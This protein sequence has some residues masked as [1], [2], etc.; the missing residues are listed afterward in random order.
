MAL[1]MRSPP[2]FEYMEGLNIFSNEPLARHNPFDPPIPTTWGLSSDD[3]SDDTHPEPFLGYSQNR[4]SEVT[5]GSTLLSTPPTEFLQQ[6]E[7]DDLESKEVEIASDV[8][9][10]DESPTSLFSW[11]RDVSYHVVHGGKTGVCSWEDSE[12]YP[13]VKLDQGSYLDLPVG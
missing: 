10:A 6:G 8:V 13:Q 1:Y 5:S 11:R 9:I 3:D 12:L 7:N 2:Q 4:D